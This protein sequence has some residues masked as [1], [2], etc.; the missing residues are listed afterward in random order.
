VVCRTIKRKRRVQC[1]VVVPAA[2]ARVQARV[3]R[4]GRVLLRRTLRRSG[5][6][7]LPAAGRLRL[8]TVGRDGARSRRTINLGGNGRDDVI[9]GAKGA[10]NNGRSGSGPSYVVRSGFLPAVDYDDPIVAQTGAPLDVSPR[11]LK[12]SSLATLSV[13]PALPAG[14]TLDPGT[15]RITGTPT[16]PGIGDYTVT[17]DD[18]AGVSADTFRLA[19]VNGQGPDGSPGS[20]GTPGPAGPQGPQGLPG[21]PGAPGSPGA[22]GAAGAAGAPGVAGPTGPAGSTT[23]PSGPK[24][25]SGARGPG[26]PP[27]QPGPDGAAVVPKSCFG[28]PA[29]I[30]VR[31]GQS[32]V[33]GTR[34]P[35]VIV[36]TASREVI[37]GRGGNDR[38]CAGAGNDTVRGGGGDDRIFGDTG[39]DRLD[40]AAGDDYLRGG[41][42]KDAITGGTGDD[43][44]STA[45][46][47]TDSS[48]CGPGH[49]AIKLDRVD[50][51]R[52]CEQVRTVKS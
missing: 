29:T 47:A 18:P 36:G 49:D 20:P 50:T 44:V 23:G 19:V 31:A 5:T 48:D 8:T 11:Q 13:A 35:D 17:V 42:A 41:G 26:G 28:L 51:Q 30:V 6:L 37:K 43:S 40:G 46:N 39:L 22:P 33:T 25:A 38:I 14:L 12:A 52:H 9:V 27:G 7:V 4:A 21:A 15:G 16:V 1:H 24:G 3:T 10:D 45:G 34:G 32:R 2:A